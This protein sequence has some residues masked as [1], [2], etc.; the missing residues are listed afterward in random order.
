MPA[1]NFS[2]IILAKQAACLLSLFGLAGCLNQTERMQVPTV[3]ISPPVPVNKPIESQ[4]SFALGKV[5]TSIRRG[6]VIAHYPTGS[7]LIGSN[8]CNYRHRGKSTIEWGSGSKQ[9]GGWR[10]ELGEVFFEVLRNRGMN[11][12]GDPGALFKQDEEAQG[13]EYL[14]G[15]RIKELRGN[16]CQV[17]HWFDG[18]PLDKYSGEFFVHVEWSVYSTLTERTV[19]RIDT[20]GHF[21]REEPTQ[22]GIM[23]AF[24]G[25]FTAATEN[26]LAERAFIGLMEREAVVRDAV[27]QSPDV[28]GQGNDVRLALPKIKESNLPIQ[29]IIG[30]VVSSVVSVRVGSGG[31]SGFLI[32]KSGHLLT[33]QH[34]VKLAK[35]VQIVFSNG[36][37]VRGEVLRRDAKNDVALVQIPIRARSVLPIRWKTV[38]QIEDVY[39]VGSPMGERQRASVTKGVVS[40]LRINTATGIRKIQADA[41]ISAGNSG[42]P[43]LDKFG[44]VVAITVSHLVHK[45]AQNVNFFIPIQDALK[46]LGIELQST[47]SSMR[48]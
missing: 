16:F 42:G 45:R 12:V 5:V 41:P 44:N 48:K 15:A 19:A 46:A 25:A 30:Q 40:A 4:A 34:V 20:R 9:F 23:T 38:R 13:A 33:N 32:S 18:R 8:F 24:V 43:L 22:Q 6:T 17:H 31:G 11:V 21:N 37:E 47:A 28:T 39:A 2:L 7:S 29:R 3:A 1:R 36:L 10:S 35:Y 26:L 14:L 27:A